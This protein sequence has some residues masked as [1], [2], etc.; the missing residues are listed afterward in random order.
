M[1]TVA[2]LLEGAFSSPNAP[3]RLLLLLLLLL[4]LVSARAPLCGGLVQPL[5]AAEE[6][7]R[8]PH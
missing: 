2:S 8:G 6:E 5:A 1:E 4:S 7:E 3:S